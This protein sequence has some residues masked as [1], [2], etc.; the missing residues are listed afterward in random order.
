M[1]RATVKV[2]AFAA[3]F[4]AGWVNSA[5]AQDAG[6]DIVRF[7]VDGNSL[8][9]AERVQELVAPFVGRRK[10]YGDVQKALEALE[11]DYR[12]LG[13]GTVQVYVPE[14]E[15]TSGVVKVQV[16]EG[17]VG[18]VT[19]TGN[20]YFNNENVRAGLPQLQEGKAP[21]MRQLSENVQL[22]NENP[23]KQVEV[24]LGTSEEEGK[25]DIKVEVKEE[26]PERFYVTLDNTGTKASGKHRLG[27][28]Y[29]NA[30]IGNSDQVLTL[31]Y[32]TAVDP[33][34]GMKILGNRMFPTQDGDGVKVDIF[35]IGYR[36][37]LYSLGDSIDFIYGNSSTD[38]PASSPTLGGVWGS[39]ARARCSGSATTIYSRVPGSTPRNWCLATITS[40]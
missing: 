24:T 36:L 38:T 20:K 27:F 10:V 6:F 18:K 37:P 40:T 33:P 7:Q 34:G 12:R 14:Q 5:I 35:S 30:N 9:P 2:F 25:V 22:S 3:F 29:Q 11:S 1:T 19:I 26:D 8:L 31:A 4:A 21:N 17:V 15:L 28:S 39:T 23:A 16:S 13:Y 32:T